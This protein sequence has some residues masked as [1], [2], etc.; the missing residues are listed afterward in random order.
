MKKRGRSSEMYRYGY[1]T[2]RKGPFITFELEV[3][4]IFPPHANLGSYNA[5]VMI[6]GLPFQTKTHKGTVK[7]LLNVYDCT[8][9][10]QCG[11]TIESITCPKGDPTKVNMN[12]LVRQLQEEWSNGC[13]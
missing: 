6:T 3:T 7:I 11:I 8:V 2:N 9:P 12:T 4:K 13:T 10:N 5:L 1:P